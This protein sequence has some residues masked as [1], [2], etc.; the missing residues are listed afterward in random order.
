MEKVPFL[1]FASL[2][3]ATAVLDNVKMQ[4]SLLMDVNYLQ[5][6]Q[7]KPI[8]KAVG[9]ILSDRQQKFECEWHHTSGLSMEGILMFLVCLL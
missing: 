3:I 5:W 9:I 6:K 8:L 4:I 7:M 1:L 2:G